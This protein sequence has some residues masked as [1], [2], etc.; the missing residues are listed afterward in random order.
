M[1]FNLSGILNHAVQDFQRGSFEEAKKKLNYI[2]NI[3]PKNLP[4]LEIFGIILASQGNQELAIKYFEKIT[5][6]NPNYA[7]A[8]FNLG[9]AQFELGNFK[10]S[11]I[12]FDKSISLESNNHKSWLNKGAA[13]AKLG[14]YEN[15]IESFEKSIILNP[16]N[17]ESFLN[18]GN[19]FFDISR[20]EDAL[21]FY[22]KAID[23]E[24]NSSEAWSG[25]A[26]VFRKLGQY[27]N[28]LDSID[29]SLGIMPE[30]SKSWANK[31]NILADLNRFFEAEEC[32]RKAVS[33]DALN[34]DAH[35][36][37]IFNSNYLKDFSPQNA[38]SEAKVFGRK[39]SELSKP[40]FTSWN[41][42]SKLKK[43][44]IGFVS[45]DL[46][47][48]SVGYFVEGLLGQ[49]DSSQFE[50]IAF[51]TTPANDDLTTRLKGFVAEWCPIYGVLDQAAASLIH[52]KGIHILF[53]LS[54]HT[55]HN[56]LAVFSFKPA[57]I[58]VSWLGLPMTTGVP[59]M[60]F[61]LGD[62]HALPQMFEDQFTEAVWR[63]PESYLCLNP[64]DVRVE[65]GPLPALI[66][67]YITF[68]SF[69][70]LSK[71]NDRVVEV[72]A[73]ILKSMPNSR[74]LLKNKQLSDPT[75]CSMTQT[76]FERHGVTADR[77]IL[78][79]V[80]DTR[81][82]HLA[83]YNEVDIALD[84]FHYPGVTTSAEALWM[85]V[86]V[87]CLNGD[88]FLSCTAISI[89]KNVGLNNWIAS[90]VEDY[91][92]KAIQFAVDQ[93]SLTQLRTNLRKAVLKSS[94]FDTQRFAK[95]FG[96]V[97]L[98]MWNKRSIFNE[99]TESL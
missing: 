32:F 83:L 3:Q 59:E 68:G 13:L 7:Q 4:A 17:S 93:D 85:G 30:S 37:L 45:G 11:I 61:V 41:F 48:H 91:I 47:K 46:N 88:D 78:K 29:K 26:I 94:L 69:N 27:E 56:R 95:N 73:K 43:L 86:P 38:L 97:L 80:L 5:K 49:L 42:S 84:T 1:N 39:V 33:Y 15:S 20:Y 71:I 34:L 23:I 52:Q 18:L 62:P 98:E 72:W 58:Q 14:L 92:N 19:V 82:E 40:K 24:P 28:A 77:L 57:P 79:S 65:T 76:R 89:A 44:R 8:W 90:D 21:L 55:A 74:L 25:R 16:D 54:G 6:I 9:T 64:P 70:N 96:S 67:G 99:N 53:D 31:G 22:K 51:P 35:S 12:A 87:L 2:L 63:M 66:N 36:N 75:V 10:K 50:I 60:D 81:V